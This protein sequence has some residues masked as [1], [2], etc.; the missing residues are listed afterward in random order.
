MHLGCSVP[1]IFANFTFWHSLLQNW[2]GRGYLVTIGVFKKGICPK[3]E[4]HHGIMSPRACMAAPAPPQMLWGR[5][6]KIIWSGEFRYS[7]LLGIEITKFVWQSLCGCE[8]LTEPGRAVNNIWKR[9]QGVQQISSWF[10]HI[11]GSS[12]K[13][14]KQIIHMRKVSLQKKAQSWDFVPT[15][16]VDNPKFGRNFKIW[17][18]VLNFVKNVKFGQTWTFKNLVNISKFCQKF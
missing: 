4:T 17:S 13:L 8:L 9:F 7:N 14:A 3:F 12:N 15:R 1:I 2:H 10:Q 18:K 11:A 5:H 16:G 6:D